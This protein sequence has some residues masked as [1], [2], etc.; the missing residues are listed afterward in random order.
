LHDTPVAFF[1]LRD[2]RIRTTPRMLAIFAIAGGIFSSADNSL[3]SSK[4]SALSRMT[5]TLAE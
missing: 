2:V 4:V 1:R 5:R 3:A